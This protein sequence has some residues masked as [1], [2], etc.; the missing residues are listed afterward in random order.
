MKPAEILE[1]IQYHLQE[2]QIAER[3]EKVFLYGSRLHGEDDSDVDILCI[4]K[5]HSTWQDRRRVRDVLGELEL[6][7]DMLFD[8]RYVESQ[9]LET[10]Q[11]KQPFVMSAFHD[12][13]SVVIEPTA[14]AFIHEPAL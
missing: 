11:A 12:G 7:F 13:L 14:S 4:M 3:V 5:P 1:A 2:N 10:I 8:V 6:Q 9:E